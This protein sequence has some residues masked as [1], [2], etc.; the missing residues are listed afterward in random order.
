[1]K[2]SNK[3]EREIRLEE[4][5]NQQKSEIKKLKERDKYAI[6]NRLK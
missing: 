1:M 2:K 3:T 5:I 6:K 4:K